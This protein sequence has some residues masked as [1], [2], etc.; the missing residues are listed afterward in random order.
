MRACVQTHASQPLRC[1]QT[2]ADIDPIV[3]MMLV[4]D[5]RS[6]SWFSFCFSRALPL[7]SVAMEVPRSSGGTDELQLL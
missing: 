6:K 1:R 3:K 7:L 2:A 5:N 4:H